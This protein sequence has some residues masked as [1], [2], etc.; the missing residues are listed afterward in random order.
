[1]VLER[2]GSALRS[3]TSWSQMVVHTLLERTA[4]ADVAARAALAEASGVLTSSG[5]VAMRLRTARAFALL[6]ATHNPSR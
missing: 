6:I 4:Y 1:M 3:R 2:R 5:V